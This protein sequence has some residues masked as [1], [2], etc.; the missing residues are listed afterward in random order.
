MKDRKS[1]WKIFGPHLSNK[2][3]HSKEDYIVS[4]NE[5]LINDKKRVANL[6]NNYSINIIENCTEKKLNQPVLDPLKDTI[7]QII[8]TYKNHPSI[9]MIN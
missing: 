1:F 3:H 8:E 7:D 6:F 9:L 4:Q 5:K 2:G